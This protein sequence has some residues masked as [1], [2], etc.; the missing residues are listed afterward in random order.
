[1]KTWQK[2]IKHI[3]WSLEKARKM[4]SHLNVANF[5]NIS[6]NSFHCRCKCWDVVVNTEWITR[7]M[8]T[9]RFCVS[10]HL[11]APNTS[12]TNKITQ[13]TQTRIRWK[14]RWGQASGWES[15][16]RVAIYNDDAMFR[17]VLRPCCV[18]MLTAIEWLQKRVL[19]YET[20]S[21]FFNPN[22][23]PYRK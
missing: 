12:H 18:I 9:H 4:P 16:A 20:S 6:R 11:L 10:V 23:F 2:L 14:R 5:V 7:A 8:F 22:S 21:R 1:M 3:S 13:Q 15:A 17:V 19:F